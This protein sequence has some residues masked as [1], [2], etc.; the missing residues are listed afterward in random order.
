MADEED[1]DNKTEAPT[2][3]RRE[4]A[5]EDGQVVFSPDLTSGFL[6]FC[7]ALGIWMFGASWF[8]HF[9][10][11]IAGQISAAQP[12]EWGVAQTMLSM[13][14]LG[15]QIMIVSGF[16][17]IGA[18]VLNSATSVMQ[19]GLGFH[20]KPLMFDPGKLSVIKGWQR[21]W[22]LDSL[23]KGFQAPMKLSAVIIAAG[24]FIWMASDRVSLSTRGSLLQSMAYAGGLA[25]MLMMILSGIALTFGVLD[26][27]FKW[28]RHEQKLKMSLEDLKQE[29]KDEQGDQ[30][31]KQQMRKSAKEGRKRKTLED[32]PT[33]S[34]VITN[35][36]HFAVAVRYESGSSA[37]IVVAKGADHF[38]R[39]I[40]AK[41]KEHGVPVM[42]RKPVARALFALTEVGDEIPLELYRAVA[43]I[44]ANVYR[45]KTTGATIYS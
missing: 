4:S 38:A 36:T 20:S 10:L 32:V 37:P 43:E 17:V 45:K 21:L 35:P 6:L 26:F 11:T 31:V 41:A 13:R 14:W 2:D 33:A 18:W 23:M 22:S 12:T 16:V 9:S 8:R 3:R 34:V 27:A 39:Q 15:A 28:Y 1:N 19:A 29:H 30:H 7:M 5:R 44:L 25:T 24:V 40:I 42:E